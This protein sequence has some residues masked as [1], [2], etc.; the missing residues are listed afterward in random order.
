M[1]QIIIKLIVLIKSWKEPLII[2]FIVLASYA[3][4]AVSTYKCIQDKKN[5]YNCGIPTVPFMP[6]PIR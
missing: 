4:M 5:E 2:C 3:L 6:I 1:K